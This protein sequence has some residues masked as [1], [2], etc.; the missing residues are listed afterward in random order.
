MGVRMINS[1][2]DNDIYNQLKGQV[3]PTTTTP[4]FDD[5]EG[6]ITIATDGTVNDG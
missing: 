2:G 3:F 6:D 4:R 1:E 5:V